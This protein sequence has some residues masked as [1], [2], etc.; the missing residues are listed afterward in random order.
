MT[1]WL[2]EKRVIHRL[3]VILVKVKTQV[4]A[5]PEVVNEKDSN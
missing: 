2:H 5:S 1:L 3:A 4:L